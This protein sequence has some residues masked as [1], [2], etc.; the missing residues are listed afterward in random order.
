MILRILLAIE[1][2]SLIERIE[3]LLPADDVLVTRV[4]DPSTFWSRLGEESCDLVIAHSDSLPE[5]SRLEASLRALRE[6]TELVAIAAAE[7][8]E[9]RANLQAAGVLAV[10]NEHLDD[11]ALLRAF[12]GVIDRLRKSAGQLHQARAEPVERPMGELSSASPKMKQVLRLAERVATSDSSLLILGETGTGK[13]W[14]A[15]GIHAASRRSQHPFVAL[16]CSAVPDSLLESELF[17]HERGSFTG[18]H[19]AR[20]G[21][22]ELAHRGTLFL[23]EIGEMPGVLQAKLLRVLQDRQVRRV[24]SEQAFE[25]DVRIVAATNRQ[26]EAAIESGELRRDLYF[27]LAVVALELPPL[28]ERGEDILALF[29]SQIETFRSKLGRWDITGPTASARAALLEYSWPGNVRELINVAERC[30][31]LSES[32]QIGLEDLPTE[33][34]AS[35]LEDRSTDLLSPEILTQTLEEARDSL[36][37]R[38][39]REYLDR[40]LEETGGNVGKTARRAGID[41]RTL[42]NKMRAYGLKKESYRPSR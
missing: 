25:V 6:E 32:D 9:H 35:S 33:I 13:E 36:V 12:A 30:V 40:M 27:R 15:R 37:A 38:F 29:E 19:R 1:S 26:P 21:Y 11:D 34:T 16:N 17:G 3:A 2:P 28:R 39:E 5:L 42:Y 41:P 24:G 23:D 18:A 14:L 10:I 8:P 31:L 20:R 22:F 7:N 4:A